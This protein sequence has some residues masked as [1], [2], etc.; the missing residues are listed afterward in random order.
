MN[1]L[2]LVAVCLAIALLGGMSRG[3]AFIHYYLYADNTG[4][5]PKTIIVEVNSDSAASPGQFF[6]E[7]TLDSIHALGFISPSEAEADAQGKDSTDGTDGPYASWVCG[8]TRSNGKHWVS[9]GSST[10]RYLPG[11]LYVWGQT[12]SQQYRPSLLQPRVEYEQPSSSNFALYL[13]VSFNSTD[14]DP[15]TTAKHWHQHGHHNWGQGSTPQVSS[16]SLDW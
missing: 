12:V 11:P 16:A 13:K 4:T 6:S 9:C 5:E 10:W 7:V 3:H 8:K 2:R 15:I 14:W 1:K